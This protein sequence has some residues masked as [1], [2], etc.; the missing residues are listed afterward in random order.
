MCVT[1]WILFF[2]PQFIYAKTDNDKKQTRD[3]FDTSDKRLCQFVIPKPMGR[4]SDLAPP[5]YF[6]DIKKIFI[7][8]ALKS[9]EILKEKIYQRTTLAALADCILARHI[10]NYG[11][12]GLRPLLIP[13]EVVQ[14]GIA[15]NSLDAGSLV[16]YLTA[17]VSVGEQ[18]E[19]LFQQKIVNVQ[20]SYFR[21]DKTL[22]ENLA[23]QCG[24]SF[25]Y[26]EGEEIQHR[27]LTYAVHT[28]LLNWY[29][30]SSPDF[31]IKTP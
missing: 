16:I 5:S 24:A 1:G 10:D 18:F 15:P 21:P 26:M 8:S 9:K 17:N 23:N 19:K 13:I 12:K 6:Q 2:S 27:L 25:P 22:P 11:N 31:Q 4:I 7:V 20:I 30:A 28:C 29:S 3:E 14:S